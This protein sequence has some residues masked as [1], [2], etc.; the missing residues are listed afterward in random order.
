M[1]LV[2]TGPR[3]RLVRVS[4]PGTATSVPLPAGGVLLARDRSAF[5]TGPA[6]ELL[7]TG[8]TRSLSGG[9][10]VK[11]LLT[12]ARAGTVGLDVPVIARA[13]SFATFSPA[14]TASPT[15]A[16]TAKNKRRG[17]GSATASPSPGA[18]PD[19]L[20]YGHPVKAV[21]GGLEFSCP[22]RTCSPGRAR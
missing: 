2:N 11:V 12:F 6:P 19:W 18:T 4:A 22:A 20:G 1:A 8:L 13:N 10:Y 17:P 21:A 5:L 7:L 3:D 15:P 16:A 14:P 9:T